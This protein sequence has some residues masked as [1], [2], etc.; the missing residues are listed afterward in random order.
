MSLLQKA[1]EKHHIPL[2]SSA[3]EAPT[4]SLLAAMEKKKPLTPGS[5]R[6]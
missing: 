1:A 2:T 5:S 3:T 4:G 6:P